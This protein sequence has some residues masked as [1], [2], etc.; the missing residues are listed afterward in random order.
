[1]HLISRDL[2]YDD[3]LNDSFEFDWNDTAEILDWEFEICPSGSLE[4]TIELTVNDTDEKVVID[5]LEAGFY[6]IF[7]YGR[8]AGSRYL[9][10]EGFE[11][12]IIARLMSIVVHIPVTVDIS[13]TQLKVMNLRTRETTLHQVEQY[14]V[15]MKLAVPA[16]N[17]I[18]DRFLVELCRN[19]T[20]IASGLLVLDGAN[21][22]V[23]LFA[24]PGLSPMVMFLTAISMAFLLAFALIELLWLGRK[25]DRR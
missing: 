4:P 15:A 23:H 25:R 11:E 21:A 7:V 9:I 12:R 5:I 13:E 20:V 14:D 24:E 10:W 16:P 18:G 22:E 6:D 2:R 19:S 3:G 17:L 1:M 8:D